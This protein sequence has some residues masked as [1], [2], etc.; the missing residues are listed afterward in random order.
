MKDKLS[1]LLDRV[2]KIADEK[3]DG[4]Y[5]IL[6]F[7]TNIRI[8]FGTPC[9]RLDFDQ[10]PARANLREGLLYAIENEPTFY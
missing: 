10:V 2:Q 4:H 9:D 3:F 7:T 5:T 6:R 1:D 8:G